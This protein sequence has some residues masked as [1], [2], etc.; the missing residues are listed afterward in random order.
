MSKRKSENKKAASPSKKGKGDSTKEDEAKLLGIFLQYHMDERVDVTFEVAAVDLDCHK[1]N[2][3]WRAVW[4]SIKDSGL[5]ETASSGKGYQIT[6]KGIESASTPEYREFMKEKNFVPATNE[7]HQER[8]KK[9]F[10]QKKSSAIFDLL[11]KH[12]SLSR[13]ELA[14]LLGEKDRSHSFSYS[15]Q[16]LVKLKKFV[17]NDPDC[18]GKRKKFRLSDKAFLKAEDRP[19]PE[20]LDAGVLAKA[21]EENA[22]PRTIISN[23]SKPKVADLNERNGKVDSKVSTKNKSKKSEKNCDVPTTVDVVIEADKEKL[24]PEGTKN[25]RD[26]SKLELVAYLGTALVEGNVVPDEKSSISNE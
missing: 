11:L 20:E 13:Y 17:E 16:E 12:G 26:A 21:V 14:G 25:D 19:Q 4:K 23:K 15:L 18:S 5:I 3:R 1:S 24:P 10:K 22:A 9:R 6:T 2:N 7:Q 8:L